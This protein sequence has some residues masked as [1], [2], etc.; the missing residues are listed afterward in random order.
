LDYISSGI[1]EF[2]VMTC[3]DLNMDVLDYTQ[4]H[5]RMK[6]FLRQ[7]TITF[8]LERCLYSANPSIHCLSHLVVDYHVTDAI[9]YIQTLDLIA[10]KN[11]DKHPKRIIDKHAAC[12]LI[13]KDTRFV[14]PYSYDLGSTENHRYALAN[15]QVLASI[16]KSEQLAPLPHLCNWVCSLLDPV[17]ERYHDENQRKA[18]EKEIEKEKINGN[19]YEI[20]DI[21]NDDSR[22]KK[23]QR[24]F[25]R[26]M[27]SYREL[28]LEERKISNRLKNPKYYADKLGQEWAATVSGIIAVLII[29]GFLMVH[30]GTGVKF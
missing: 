20:L 3:A 14:D 22:I 6:S 9:S 28:D 15:L 26:A 5:D 12:F 1:M 25:R 19:L 24:E 29:L 11:T 17:I 13:S 18:I 4:F 2:W 30:Y 7:N 27:I 8:G 16:Q 10:S 21:L 23:D